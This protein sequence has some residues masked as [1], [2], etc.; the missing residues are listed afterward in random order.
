MK[1]NPPVLADYLTTK[2]IEFS[3]STGKLGLYQVIH[4]RKAF[5]TARFIPVSLIGRSRKPMSTKKVLD[6]GE[7]QAFYTP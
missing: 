1:E 4:R 5:L 3:Y 6:K 7:K 2:R